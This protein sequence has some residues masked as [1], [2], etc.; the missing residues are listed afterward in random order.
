RGTSRRPQARRLAKASFREGERV[1]YGATEACPP[2]CDTLCS[3]VWPA[4]SG[5]RCIATPPHRGRPN[6][7]LN[8]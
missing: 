5:R 7:E 6:Q 1:C 8:S 3:S 4:E 2:T